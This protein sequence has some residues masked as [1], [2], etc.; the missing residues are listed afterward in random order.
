LQAPLREATSRRWIPAQL[1]CL[2]V[3][4]HWLEKNSRR[5]T[6]RPV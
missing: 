6:L 5:D 2:L 3:L 1:W 4:E